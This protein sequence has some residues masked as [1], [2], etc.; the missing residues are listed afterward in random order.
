MLI[1]SGLFIERLPFGFNGNSAV[2]LLEGLQMETW[3]Y[4]AIG[5]FVIVLIRA[6]FLMGKISRFIDDTD[7]RDAER[8]KDRNANRY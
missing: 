2:L 6:W 7:Y 5:A 4:L 3:Q 1:P 8:F